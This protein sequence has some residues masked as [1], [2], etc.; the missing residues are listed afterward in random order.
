M[1]EYDQVELPSCSS[2]SATSS[3]A[4]ESFIEQKPPKTK[5]LRKS[6]KPYQFVPSACQVCY[7]KATGHHYD[8]ASCNGCKSFF[9]RVT[10]EKLKYRCSAG[11]ACYTNF[12]PGDP[13]P[14]CRACRYKR[15]LEAGMNALGI[16][17]ELRKH[18]ENQPLEENSSEFGKEIVVLPRIKEPP[19]SIE[20]QVTDLIN[21]LMHLDLKITTFRDCTYNPM[22]FPTLKQAIKN[23]VSII[24]LGDRLGPMPGWPLSPETIEASRKPNPNP[25]S[26]RIL[27]PNVKKWFSYDL[28]TVVEMAKTFDFFKKLSENDRFFLCRD[29]SLMVSNLMRA[30]FSVENKTDKFIRADGQTFVPPP[31]IPK[32]YMDNLSSDIMMRA[33]KTLIRLACTKV[34]YLFLRAI[35]LCNSA[36][37]DISASGR[38]ILSTE[39]AKYTVALLNYTMTH[40]G[41]AGPGR[42]AEILNVIDVLERQ[43][44]DQRD[45]NVYITLYRPKHVKLA[46]FDDIMLT[47]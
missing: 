18:S 47:C 44:K 1:L 16:Q 33:I 11:N 20:A 9:R 6:G 19:K 41:A 23:E 14:K 30:Y 5:S 10:I 36:A 26:P 31:K 3:P 35:L 8:V 15:C 34:E 17:S 21:H 45:V 42:F 37:P 7:G 25:G 24:G 38:N 43:Q 12:G 46:L 2:A 4:L 27:P 39:R 29:T 22:S 32:E 28:L 13:V 40:H